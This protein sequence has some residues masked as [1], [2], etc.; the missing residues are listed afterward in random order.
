MTKKKILVLALSLAMVAILAV[1]GSLAYF[2]SVDSA[3]NTFTFGNVKIDLIEDFDKDEDTDAANLIPGKEIKK[4]VSVKNVGALPVYVRVHIAI[5]TALD[6][7]NPDET[8]AKA[9]LHRAFDANSTAAGKWSWADEMT[10]G[11]GYDDASE[12]GFNTY[13]TTIDDV[14]YNVY[15]VTYRTALASD[16]ETAEKA[17]SKVYLDALVD[18]T[19]DEKTKTYTYTAYDGS[20]FTL[21]ENGKVLIKVFAE[22][23]QVEGFDDAYEAL[24]TAFGIP[25]SFGY[26]S[27]FNK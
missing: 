15:V 26:T 13:T 4:E 3:D 6:A 21:P 18:A 24:N 11:D 23:T 20:T 5:P 12:Q 16:E 8:K 17:I 9:F 14:S 25:G 1:G 19:Y 7:D 10:D 22:G 2:T 27:P